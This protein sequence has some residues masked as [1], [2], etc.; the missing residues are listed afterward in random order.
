MTILIVVSV[1]SIFLCHF[2]AKARKANTTFW[3][4]AALIA[5]PLEYIPALSYRY[6]DQS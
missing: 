3:L 5:G 2:V 1:I 4:I 6:F